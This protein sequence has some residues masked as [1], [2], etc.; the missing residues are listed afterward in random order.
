M[1]TVICFCRLI[2]IY[3]CENLENIW[4]FVFFVLYIFAGKCLQSLG[5]AKNQGLGVQLAKENINIYG[6]ELIICKILGISLG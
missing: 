5:H 6:H 1:V 3:F 4:A 2:L